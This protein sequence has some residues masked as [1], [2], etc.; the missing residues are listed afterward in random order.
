M[1]SIKIIFIFVCSLFLI[2]CTTKTFDNSNNQNMDGE[3]TDPILEE[4]P[5]SDVPSIYMPSNRQLDYELYPETKIVTIKK[6]NT[7]FHARSRLEFMS[8][9]VPIIT[10]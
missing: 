4:I 3:I 10:K 5:L 7:R 2:S 6:E 1:K 8:H 9:D